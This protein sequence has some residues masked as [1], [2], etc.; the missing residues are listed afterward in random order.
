MTPDY[1]NAAIKATE[2]LIKFGISTTPIDPLPMLKKTPNVYVM[3]FSEMSEKTSVDRCDILRTLGQQNQD[4]ITTVFNENGERKYIVSYNMLLPAKY[5]DRALA[6]ELGHIVL[7]H[8]G[9]RQEDVRDAEAK[10]FANHL[11]C[12]RPLIHSIQATG[13]RFTVDMLG[14]VTGCYDYC[15]SCIQKLPPVHVPPDLN[16]KLRDQLMPYLINLFEFLRYA[17]MR[18][19]SAVADLGSFMEGYEE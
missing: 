10:C 8:D 3:T 1:E 16:R 18:D 2:T 17:S 14:S 9:S 19:G 15:L 6:R 7:G 12:P 11:L 4:A 5:V 13:I